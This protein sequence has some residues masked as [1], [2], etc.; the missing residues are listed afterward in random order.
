MMT[1]LGQRGDARKIAGC[2]LSGYLT[3]PVRIGTICASAWRWPWHGGPPVSP[4]RTLITRHTVAEARRARVRIL[5]A[6]DNTV[7]QKVLLGILKK[8]G[9]AGTP[10]PTGRG[11]HGA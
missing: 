2:G 1:S 5:V 9:T 8:L 10:S 3:K 7:N 6:E 11:R 4:T